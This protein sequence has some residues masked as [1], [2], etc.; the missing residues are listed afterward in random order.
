[1]FIKKAH[2]S[3]SLELVQS[4]KSTETHVIKK[5]VKGLIQDA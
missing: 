1:M 2:E 5:I 3:G 4:I